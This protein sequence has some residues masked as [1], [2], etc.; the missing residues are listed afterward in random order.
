[1]KHCS[2]WSQLSLSGLLFLPLMAD[3]Q[4]GEVPI[5]PAPGANVMGAGTCAVTTTPPAA[6]ATQM[7]V[8]S[9]AN[10]VVQNIASD[11]AGMSRVLDGDLQQLS[12]SQ[13]AA[14]DSLYARLEKLQLTA[15]TA[16]QTLQNTINFQSELSFPH[17]SC[18]SMSQATAMQIGSQT[19]RSVTERLSGEFA[20]HRYGFDTV[21]ARRL[22]LDK[23]D[24]SAVTA[25][26]LFPGNDTI[27]PARLESTEALAKA[28]VDPEPP[29]NL[30]VGLTQPALGRN[31]ENRRKLMNAQELPSEAAMM[32]VMTAKM[33]S[34]N[35]QAAVVRAMWEY[36]GGKGDPPGLTSEGLISPDAFLELQ[37]ASRYENPN[38]FSDTTQ[39][40]P[41][42][43]QRE[44]LLMEAVRLHIEERSYE[45]LQR[46]TVLLAT[47]NGQQVRQEHGR[48]L[49]ELHQQV[50]AGTGDVRP[51]K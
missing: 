1:M 23:I 34:I 35:G 3:A 15:L 50:I 31:Y 43:L 45:L 22:M 19:G 26:A 6:I 37:V 25:Q 2:L 39:R 30:P 11:I 47:M 42:G 24:T 17:T 7:F 46:I 18:G 29:V 36:M 9:A 5:T 10:Q 44:Q 28:I 12:V 8:A 16:Q 48:A 49:S 41:I 51:Q 32:T 21:E 40:T 13:A 38:W 14:T 33:P 27:D 20:R 4:L